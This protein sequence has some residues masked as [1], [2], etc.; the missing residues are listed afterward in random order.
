MTFRPK[1]RDAA[2]AP[3]E[4]RLSTAP[5]HREER[6]RHPWGRRWKTGRV[7]MFRPAAPRYASR[8][9][10][11][12]PGIK[13]GKVRMA[14]RFAWLKLFMQINASRMKWRKRSRKT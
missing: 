5:R 10:R 1:V 4:P 3:F 11:L 13:F 14:D 8:R 6:Q 12:G 2:F 7:G 9:V